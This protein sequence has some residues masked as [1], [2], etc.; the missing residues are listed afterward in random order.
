LRHK[1]L[2]SLITTAFIVLLST[3]QWVNAAE[4]KTNHEEPT[5]LDTF[6]DLALES[7]SEVEPAIHA[8]R[9]K[10]SKFDMPEAVT[11]IT[12]QQ[13]FE[14]GV[15][16]V[17]EIFRGVPGFRIVKIGDET[18]VSYHGTAHRQNRRMK[19]TVNG[20]SVLH[21]DGAYVEFDRLP[22]DIDD[23]A[24]VTILRGPNGASF[25]D[26]AFFASINFVLK[27]ASEKNLMGGRAAIGSN[28]NDQKAI[29]WNPTFNNNNLSLSLSEE[30][31]GGYDFSDEMGTPRNDG[32]ELRRGRF[33]IEREDENGSSWMFDASVLDSEHLV[34][35]TSIDW[36]GRQENDAVYVSIERHLNLDQDTRL[37]W[38]INY[39]NQKEK[40][41]INGCFTDEL[42]T[43]LKENTA[44]ENH[45]QLDAAAFFIPLTLGVPF[46]DVCAF[47]EIN[48]DADRYEAEIE[49]EKELGRFN[50]VIGSSAVYAKAESKEFFIDVEKQRTYRA[51][52][53][54]SYKL[55]KWTFSTGTM[56]QD[57]DNVASSETAWRASVNYH[58]SPSNHFRVSITD[59]FRIPSLVETE[60]NWSGD[61]LIGV[62]DSNDYGI[63]LPLPEVTNPNEI[64]VEKIRSYS[65]GYY[66]TFASNRL[67]LDAKIF[68][69]EIDDPVES[70]AIHFTGP[71]Q[72]LESYELDGG[73]I[74]IRY[75]VR[76]GFDMY[77]SY[78][79]L[80]NSTSRSFERSLHGDHA[81]SIGARYAFDDEAA[82]SVTY[83]GNSTISNNSYDR[84]DLAYTRQMLTEKGKL[85]VQIVFQKHV[86]GVDGIG[87]ALP[88]R[89]D[90]GYYRLTNQAFLKVNYGIR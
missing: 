24:T 55:D 82:I 57:S 61:V 62:R 87:S 41:R 20:K 77:A 1:I 34:A 78:S 80:D 85:D 74:D 73:E 8:T 32:Q 64:L 71:P 2:A 28:D 56:F 58:L 9:L 66:G 75:K 81:G 5:D 52:A 46:E 50:Y 23:I 27:S 4:V 72:N 79:Y 21:A 15:L 44:P 63:S 37:D 89:A 12:Q 3:T 49:Y 42:F 70:G 67:T 7:G 30:R 6:D 40:I 88:T 51:F 19:I 14:R 69:N 31:D 90:E 43:T 16:E 33:S 86:G 54:A 22:F 26:N 68:H 25:G 60:T 13:I 39:N 17:S 10:Y 53:E 35:L 38:Q 65:V 18:R 11:V 45:P 36:H 48:E 29:Y 76:P 83:Y 84:Y 47:T 59:S